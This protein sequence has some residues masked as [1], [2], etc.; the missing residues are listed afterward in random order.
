MNFVNIILTAAKSVKISGAIL[1]AICSHESG[2]QNITVPHDGGSP[3]YGICQVKYDTATMLGFKGKPQDLLEPKINAKYAATYLKYQYNRY[4][5]WC[6]AV[7]AYNSGTYN[8]SSK[9]PGHPRNIKYVKNVS[10]M[11]NKRFQNT[12][13][14]DRVSKGDEN[15]AENNGFGRRVQSAQ[16]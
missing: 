13:S 10:K 3:T 14:C 15:V 2:L 11:L 7:A 1:V 16:P 8:P 6:M 5:S 9:E 12:V 4:G